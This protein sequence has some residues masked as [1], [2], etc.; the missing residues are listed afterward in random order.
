[1]LATRSASA[2]QALYDPLPPK[3]SAYVRFFNALSQPVTVRPEFSQALSL[4]TAGAQ[5]IGPYTVVENVEGRSVTVPM[6]VG[7][8]QSSVTLGLHSGSFNTVLWLPGGAGPHGVVLQDES[9]FNQLRSKLT[10]YNATTDCPAASLTI[11]PD[12]PAVFQNVPVAE[13]RMRAVNPVEASLRASCGGKSTRPFDL[14]GLR[15]GGRSSIWLIM[16]NDGPQAF[17]TQDATTV[18]KR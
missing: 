6:Q 2:Q 8:G 10:F 7:D 15:E 11:T 16:T 17:F 18:W 12:G 5:R 9:Q 1:M 3:G 4:G 14:K 13:A